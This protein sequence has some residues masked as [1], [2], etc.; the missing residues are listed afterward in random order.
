MSL[1]CRL[2]VMRNNATFKAT[3]GN[4]VFLLVIQ[5]SHSV[6]FRISTEHD[7]HISGI[8]E[9]SFC[10]FIWKCRVRLNTYWTTFLRFCHQKEKKT[11]LNV[12]K[13][14][15]YKCKQEKKKE[16]KNSNRSEW[17]FPGAS[18]FHQFSSKHIET[19]HMVR[20]INFEIREFVYTHSDS[21]IIN[22]KHLPCDSA[23]S[24]ENF[25]VG[26]ISENI[27]NVFW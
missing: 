4:F 11:L 21:I 5:F 15:I 16:K 26:N 7:Y 1:W 23:C 9:N 20:N 14:K 19:Q 10:V 27:K 17:Y 25:V 12:V 2:F 3:S 24:I 6:C 18:S 22:Q 8:I 13:L